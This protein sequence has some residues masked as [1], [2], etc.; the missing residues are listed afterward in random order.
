MKIFKWLLIVLALI[1]LL[2]VGFL[3]YMGMFLPLKPYETKLGPFTIVYESFTGPY[4]QSGAVFA[5][6]SE[7]AKAA[8]IVTTRGLGIYDPGKVAAD[9]LRSDCGLVV[10]AKDLGKLKTLKDKLKVK[11]LPQ[12]PC[13]VV[14]FPLRNIL[15]YMFG[16]MKAYPALGKYAAAKG[17][18]GKMTY[19]LYDEAQKKILFVLVL[20]K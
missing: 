2:I 5:R 7:T 20:G 10:E 18:Q 11:Q 19:E 4:A 14:E 3:A 17:Y 15:S 16:P 12:S 9:K 13:V 8:G 6:V 1:A